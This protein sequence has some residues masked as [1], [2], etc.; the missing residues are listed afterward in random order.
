VHPLG[1]IDLPV[2]FGTPTNFKREV[3]TFLVVGFR[4]TYHAVFGRPCYTK[5]MAN[6]NYTYLKL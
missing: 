1:H 2:C 6:P 4:C 5:F 3:L